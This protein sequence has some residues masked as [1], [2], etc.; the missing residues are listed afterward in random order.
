MLICKIVH[1]RQR[2]C[3]PYICFFELV[4]EKFWCQNFHRHDRCYPGVW[5]KY[6]WNNWHCARC[7]P[8]GEEL[9]ILTARMKD[10]NIR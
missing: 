10:E 3:R 7:H 8:C 9:D 2:F 1:P 5:M 4:K 6:P